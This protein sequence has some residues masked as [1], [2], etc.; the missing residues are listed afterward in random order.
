M[1]ND[2]HVVGP[3]GSIIPE[4]SR[5]LRCGSGGAP[6]ATRTMRFGRRVIL[7][8]LGESG[9]VSHYFISRPNTPVSE[10]HGPRGPRVE[11]ERALRPS[12]EVHDVDAGPSFRD[13]QL[14]LHTIVRQSGFIRLGT[15]PIT[16]SARE[17]LTEFLEEDLD[18]FVPGFTFE[19]IPVQPAFSREQN[20]LAK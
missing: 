15:A 9:T 20:R 10:P 14:Q 2:R 5:L 7:V 6:A 13:V 4:F 19:I 17:F 11:V 18:L 1:R 16:M 12:R 3:F 8:G